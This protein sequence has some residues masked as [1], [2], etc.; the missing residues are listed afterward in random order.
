MQEWGDHL[1]GLITD[2]FSEMSSEREGRKKKKNPPTE[3]FVGLKGSESSCLTL[4]E[5]V[6]RE[7]GKWDFVYNNQSGD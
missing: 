3:I 2:S 4:F 1:L 7:V 6:P 5:L